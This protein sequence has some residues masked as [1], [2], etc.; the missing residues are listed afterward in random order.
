LRDGFGHGRGH[1]RILSPRCVDRTLIGRGRS[2]RVDLAASPALDFRRRTRQSAG[3]RRFLLLSLVG[4][5]GCGE[6][7]E[8]NHFAKRIDR[9][10]PRLNTIPYIAT[11]VTY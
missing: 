1:G 3:M 7:V 6:P 10:R 5:S 11:R 4:L 9:K 8:D 2:A